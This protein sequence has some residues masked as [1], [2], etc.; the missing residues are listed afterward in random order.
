MKIFAK[1][2]LLFTL[3]VVC[4]ITMAAVLRAEDEDSGEEQA[5][6]CATTERYCG[7]TVAMFSADGSFAPPYEEGRCIPKEQSCGDF[8]CGNRRCE[9]GFFGTPSVCCINNS[10][11]QSVEYRCA[12]SELS[13]PGNR[14]QLTIRNGM[15]R[16]F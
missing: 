13:C 9:S 14:E 4:S 2:V 6:A 1:L 16:R 10:P 7:Y 3:T 8:W 11:G 12:Y 15:A 5:T